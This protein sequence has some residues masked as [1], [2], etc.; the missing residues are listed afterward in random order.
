MNRQFGHVPD[1]KLLHSCEKYSFYNN[2]GKDG[3]RV[4][5]SPLWLYVI[6]RRLLETFTIHTVFSKFANLAQLLR[7]CLRISYKLFRIINY[8]PLNCYFQ[9]SREKSADIAQHAF[10]ISLNLAGEETIHFPMKRVSIFKSPLMYFCETYMAHNHIYFIE[11]IAFCWTKLIYH[12][13]GART[14]GRGPLSTRWA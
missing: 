5:K 9:N 13:L 1:C 6:V 11:L 2:C 14:N 4:S 10:I 8:A 12:V 3:V 7:K